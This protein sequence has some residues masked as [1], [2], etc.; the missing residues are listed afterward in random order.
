MCTFLSMWMWTH[1]YVLGSLCWPLSKN[2]LQWGLFMKSCLVA[3]FTQTAMQVRA[4]GKEGAVRSVRAVGGSF[5]KWGFLY[6]YSELCRFGYW[7]INIRHSGKTKNRKL[8]PEACLLQTSSSLSGTVSVGLHRKP[9]GAGGVLPDCSSQIFH[10]ELSCFSTQIV[11]K[12]LPNARVG[13]GSV[14]CCPVWL[15]SIWN[16]TSSNWDIL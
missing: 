2:L 11:F 9:G 14:S 10:F 4:V 6:L 7:C 3:G 15:W 16:V 1:K 5:I 13:Q 12:V 8:S